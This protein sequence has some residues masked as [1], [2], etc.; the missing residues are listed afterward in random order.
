MDEVQCS[1]GHVE[2]GGLDEAEVGE[3]AVDE[4]VGEIENQIYVVLD[5]SV[6]VW[7]FEPLP[8]SIFGSTRPLAAALA[9]RAAR[10]AAAR[11]ARCARRARALIGQ[12]MVVATLL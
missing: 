3:D 7:M 10:S 6:R 11:A 5:W 9:T 12:D 8:A 4:F 1:A 2:V